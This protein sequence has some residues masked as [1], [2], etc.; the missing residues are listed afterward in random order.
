MLNGH[1]PGVQIVDLL[2]RH[3]PRNGNPVVPGYVCRALITLLCKVRIGGPS[4]DEHVGGGLG[5]RVHLP[6]SLL[7]G[8]LVLGAFS[9]LLLYCVKI[10]T[11]T[12]L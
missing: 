6:L 11:P 12:C 1:G 10:D 3:H 5:P 4:T 2:I 9:C 8:T 7:K